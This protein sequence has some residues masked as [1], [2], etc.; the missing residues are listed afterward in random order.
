MPC[1]HGVR[2]YYLSSFWRKNAHGR[3]EGT[4]T[5]GHECQAEA[6]G[7]KHLEWEHQPPRGKE[8]MSY[9][10]PTVHSAKFCQTLWPGVGGVSH[11]Y[12]ITGE[13]AEAP[14]PRALWN[15]PEII[16]GGG[17]ALANGRAGGRAGSE[18]TLIRGREAGD[19]C[20]LLKRNIHFNQRQISES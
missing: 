4:S 2:T 9:S 3:E 17:A 20:V 14:S 16:K 11:P 8:E 6:C 19:L 10:S 12:T 7:G 13:E 18:A 5:G 15:K 1:W